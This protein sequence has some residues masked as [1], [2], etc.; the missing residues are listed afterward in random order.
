MTQE[1]S[2]LSK[3]VKAFSTKEITL[4]HSVIGYRTNAYFPKHKLVIEVDE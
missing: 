2:M 3:I 1:Q 4:Q